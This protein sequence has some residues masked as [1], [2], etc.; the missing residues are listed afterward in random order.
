MMAELKTLNDLKN[1]AD[2]FCGEVIVISYYDLR[3]IGVKL[4]KFLKDKIKDG[5]HH[6]DLIVWNA[7]ID[8]IKHF[9]NITEEDLR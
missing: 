1:R 6:H 3:A 4:I 5:G 2:L 7:Q 9:F 8:W